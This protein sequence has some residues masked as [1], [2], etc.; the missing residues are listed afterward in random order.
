VIDKVRATDGRGSMMTIAWMIAAREL[1]SRYLGSAIGYFWIVLQ[2]VM[3]SVGFLVIRS[4]LSAPDSADSAVN[5]LPFVFVGVLVFQVWYESIQTQND[6]MRKAVV[7]MKTIPIRPEV[8][9]LSNLMISLVEALVRILFVFLAL[10]FFQPK[11]NAGFYLFPA[12]FIAIVISGNCIGYIL[13]T[14]GSFYKDIARFLS[15]FNVAVLLLSPVFYAATPDPTS[16]IHLLQALNPV[17]SG[18]A[19]MRNTLWGGEDGFTFA[20]LCGLLV[21]LLFSIVIWRFYARNYLLIVERL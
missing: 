8:F 7:F 21:L 18:L 16:K 9:V 14:F 10:A 12:I 19:F 15:A 17:A 1:K 6:Y 20:F 3:Y 5:S 4:L 2:P 13:S 11:L